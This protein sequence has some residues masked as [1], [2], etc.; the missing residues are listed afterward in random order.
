MYGVKK[1]SE[2][3]RKG[4]KKKRNDTFFFVD[5]L[6][7]DWMSDCELQDPEDRVPYSAL[8][9]VLISVRQRDPTKREEIIGGPVVPRMTRGSVNLTLV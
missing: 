8:G 3:K 9:V 2:E 1:K 6:S 5:A 4:R 7:R